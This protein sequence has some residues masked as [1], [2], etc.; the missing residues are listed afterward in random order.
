MTAHVVGSLGDARVGLLM[1]TM[2]CWHLLAHPAARLMRRSSTAARRRLVTTLSTTSLV[3]MVRCQSARCN[4]AV[5]RHVN[6]LQPSNLFARSLRI[7]LLPQIL[8][9]L[10]QPGASQTPSIRSRVCLVLSQTKISGK[11]IASSGWVNMS[12]P[13]FWGLFSRQTG[14]PASVNSPGP[15]PRRTLFE[16]V[17]WGRMA[18]LS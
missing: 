5:E 13:G 15:S 10:I 4:N 14:E 17:A 2:W 12:D 1:V 9:A 6:I 8:G 18:N 16:R 11:I 7:C 3:T